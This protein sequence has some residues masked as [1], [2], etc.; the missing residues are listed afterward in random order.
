M[1]PVLKYSV[2][3]LAILVIAALLVFAVLEQ[4]NPA[5]D[6]RDVAQRS[7]RIFI[8]ECPAKAD[9]A[10]EKMPLDNFDTRESLDREILISAYRH[11][12]SIMINSST[13]LKYHLVLS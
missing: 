3:V 6:Y 5:K 7:Y 1:K 11:S 2:L 12:S 8:P 9:F 10:G 13:Y 4:K